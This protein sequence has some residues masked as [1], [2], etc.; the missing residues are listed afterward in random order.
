[1]YATHIKE[2]EMSRT[3]KCRDIEVAKHDPKKTVCCLD[4]QAI[5]P[6]PCGECSSLY[7]K[8]KLS[9]YNLTI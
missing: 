1:M 3:A 7:Y 8:R 6:S 4:M 5:H 2:K 9:C